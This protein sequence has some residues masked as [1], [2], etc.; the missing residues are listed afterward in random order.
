MDVRIESQEGHHV[1]EMIPGGADLDVPGRL[2]RGALSPK[3]PATETAGM[4]DAFPYY[5]GFSFEWARGKISEHHL[6]SDA[7]VLD[8]WNGSGT[9]TLA[10]NSLGLRAIGIDR[11][12]VAN[13]VARLRCGGNPTLPLVLAPCASG[14]RRDSS[15]PLANWFTGRTVHRLREWAHTFSEMPTS[16]IGTVALFRVVRA[17]SRSF[18]GSNP[19]WVKRAKSEADLVDINPADIDKLMVSEQQFLR[20][21]L[22]SLTRTDAPSGI[23]TADSASLPLA[24]QSVDLILTSPPYLTRIDYAVAYARELAVLDIDIFAE[25]DLRYALMGTTLTRTQQPSL[26]LGTVATDLL[27]QVA[28]H[29]SK[30][31]SG[32]YLKQVQQYLRDLSLGMD[33]VSRVAKSNAE[34]HLVVQDS[35]YKDVPVPL[36]QMCIEEAENRSW[37]F[38]K[39]RPYAVRRLLTSL[40]KSAQAY[41]KG[42]VSETVITFRR[43]K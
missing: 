1:Q 14:R 41:K 21:R 6:A 31:S 42:E 2:V 25:K 3:R 12:P 30:A 22:S 4:A 8:P 39:S 43:T 37:N 15:D 40:N 26:T 19:T 34:M 17:N 13:I 29:D 23:L 10:A 27:E 20:D 7:V 38:V 18:E 36:A 33:E 9:T 5:A 16:S 24:S 32:Y 35:Y 28:S 11:N